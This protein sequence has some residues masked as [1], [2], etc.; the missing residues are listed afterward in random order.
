MRREENSA[1]EN[2]SKCGKDESHLL[3]SADS[4]E[5]AVQ[6]LALFYN[7][8]FKAIETVFLSS[9][10]EI[11]PQEI[12][13]H[14]FK[15]ERL[16][17]CLGQYLQAKNMRYDFHVCIYHRSRFNGNE[18]WFNNGLFDSCPAVSSFFSKL[19]KLDGWNDEWDTAE[20]IALGNVID[21][22]SGSNMYGP[23]AFDVLDDAKSACN[24]GLDYSQPEFM[25][26]C[27]WD[28]HPKL[29]AAVVTFIQQKTI[30][31]VVKFRALP[32]STDRY[33]NHLWMY[34]HSIKFN[35]Q[36]SDP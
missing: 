8:D 2:S 6:S 29:N 28:R 5:D 4:P 25:M 26:G 14:E 22:D 30:P 34:L 9:W 21:R 7:L 36:Y 20:A 19:R 3:L 31:V 12:D 32:E 17:W 33:I 15:D 1:I 13:Y 23:H 24:A 16:A 11:L 35:V 27:E 18:D 10:P